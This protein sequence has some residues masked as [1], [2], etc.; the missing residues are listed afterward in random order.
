MGESRSFSLSWLQQYNI[1][2]DMYID[3]NIY[4][5]LRNTT[6]MYFISL[7]FHSGIGLI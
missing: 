7:K 5:V 3:V 6:C 1:I 2:C 4:H